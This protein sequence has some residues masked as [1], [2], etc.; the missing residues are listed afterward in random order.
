MI[1]QRGQRLLQSLKSQSLYGEIFAA[2]LVPLKSSDLEW[3]RLPLGID[4]H[5]PQIS[6][7][8][9]RLLFAVYESPG[10]SI[11]GYEGSLKS[12]SASPILERAQ[13][14][15]KMGLLRIKL[16]KELDITSKG[17]DLVGFI[18]TVADHVYG[19]RAK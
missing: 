11:E 8:D 15:E 2:Q 9:Y 12:P 16:L 5:L 1:N 4:I 10:D 13:R 19:S 14:L 6:G 18:K 3:G 17:R 7:N